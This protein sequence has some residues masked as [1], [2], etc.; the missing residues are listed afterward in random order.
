VLVLVIHN[1]PVL[2]ETHHEAASEHDIGQIAEFVGIRLEQ[3]GYG[4]RLLPIDRN[5]GALREVLHEIEPDCVFNLFEGF[6]DD[7]ASEWQVARIL[8]RS[9]LPFTG[10]LSESLRIANSKHLTKQLLREAGLPTPDS[11][12]VERLPMS[13]TNLPWPVIAKPACRDGSVGI[14]RGSVV[15]DQPALEERVAC[16]L[17]QYG[18]PVLVEQYIPGRE[19]SVA[20]VELPE[21]VALPASEILFV[22]QD[23]SRCPIVTYDAKWT[24]G[25]SEYEATP[26]VYSAKIAPGL[27][28]RLN[29][30]A[31]RAFRLVECRDYGRVDFRVDQDRPY[32]LEVNPNPCFSPGAGLA[33]AMHA[34]GRD[35][36]EFTVELVRRATAR[37]GLEP[38]PFFSPGSK[39][40]A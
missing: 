10:A 19:L 38:M 13:V 18:P 39:K 15:S 5:L 27:A 11:W 37:A 29:D 28:D 21:L 4:V 36:G 12:V 35:H 17:A 20:L 14:D 6:A 31:C 24:P 8:E 32:I 3:A 23:M 2:P 40:D 30:L 34:A 33:A 1:K 16:L 22:G 25:S 26:P 9:G 7:A